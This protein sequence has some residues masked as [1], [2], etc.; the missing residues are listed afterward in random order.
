M[1]TLPRSALEV[2]ETEFFL[3]LLVSLLANPTSLDGS[4]ERAQVSLCRQVGE[5]VFLLSRHPMFSDEPSLLA[6]QM[7]LTLVPDPLRRSVGDPHA[8]GS[9]TSRE[10]KVI[11]QGHVFHRGVVFL[12]MGADACPDFAVRWFMVVGKLIGWHC[13]GPTLRDANLGHAQIVPVQWGVWRA[14]ISTVLKLHPY[15]LERAARL[16]SDRMP[17]K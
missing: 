8:S 6:G 1:Q 12:Q 2:I 14:V 16:R 4:R 15:R 5:I 10:D 3:Q 9:K 11:R 13:F 7:L 17:G